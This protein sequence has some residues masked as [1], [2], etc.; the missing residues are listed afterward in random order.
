M[1]PQSIEVSFRL[2]DLRL[3]PGP[4]G[5][6]HDVHG[7]LVRWGSADEVGEVRE[8]EVSRGFGF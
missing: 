1:G 2:L 6:R 7:E 8:G 5:L 3:L 4:S